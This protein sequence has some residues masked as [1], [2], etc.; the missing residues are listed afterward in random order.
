MKGGNFSGFPP[1]AEHYS[2]IRKQISILLRTFLLPFAKWKMTNEPAVP[3]CTPFLLAVQVSPRLCPPSAHHSWTSSYLLG[4]ASN[5]GGGGGGGGGG[6]SGGGLH[7]QISWQLS[8]NFSA[9]GLEHDFWGSPWVICEETNHCMSS[10]TVK[11]DEC[12]F[13]LKYL[14]GTSDL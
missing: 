14:R 12:V 10:R 5:L 13:R 7:W 8:V 4:T 2:L 1:K 3:F 6:N 11:T 9:T